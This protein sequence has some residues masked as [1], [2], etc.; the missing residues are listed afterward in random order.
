MISELA[1]GVII[2]AF[3]EGKKVTQEIQFS[4]LIP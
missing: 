2:V 4:A 1:P 3:S